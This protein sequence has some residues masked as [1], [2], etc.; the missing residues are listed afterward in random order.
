M[1]NPMAIAM[2]L[3]AA[4]RNANFGLQNVDFRPEKVSASVAL[5]EFSEGLPCLDVTPSASPTSV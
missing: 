4:Q 3:I 2:P 5:A 1:P